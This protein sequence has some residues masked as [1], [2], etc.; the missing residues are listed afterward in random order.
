MNTI[1]YSRWYDDDPTLSLAISLLKNT[2]E[3]TRRACAE[4][5]VAKAQENG[6]KLAA[7]FIES[8][9]YKL[10]RWYDSEKILFDAVEYLRIATEEIRKE[11]AHEIIQY[12]ETSNSKS[13]F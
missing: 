3:Q 2:S 10:K 12:L 1:K 4:L 13:V 7:N 8:V 11:I 6:L 5:V 9:S